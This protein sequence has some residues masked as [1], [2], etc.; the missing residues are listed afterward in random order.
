MKC[1][2]IKKR[3]DSYKTFIQNIHTKSQ[4]EEEYHHI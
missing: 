4:F 1:G 2:G 3:K